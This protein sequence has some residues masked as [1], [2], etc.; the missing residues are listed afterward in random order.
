V[1]SGTYEPISES[2]RV[3][4]DAVLVDF[5]IPTRRQHTSV[6]IIQRRHPDRGLQFLVRHN[7]DWGYALPA[8]RWERPDSV[9]SGDLPALAQAAAERVAREELGLEPGKDVI[10]T[11]ALSP[12]FTTHA[13]SKTGGAP[14]H[15]AETDY[16]H[17][18]FDAALRHPE[19]LRSDR[20]LAWVT[21]EEILWFRTAAAHGEPG[22]PQGF[23]GD[24]SR[25]VYEI[26]MHLGLVAELVEPDVNDLAEDM[27]RRMAQKWLEEHGGGLG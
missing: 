7:A 26:L 11:P 10:L 12:E 16:I 17:S 23:S 20:A 22:A 1:L 27:I 6:L 3:I 19:K 13:T 9:K 25:T 8:K 18:L 4:L 24:V 5:E 21:P 2:A 14:A 15:G